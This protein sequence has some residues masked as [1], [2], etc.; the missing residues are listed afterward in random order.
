MCDHDHVAELRR[1]LADLDGQRDR[2]NAAFRQGFTVGFAHGFDL[3]EKNRL[4]EEAELWAALAEKVRQMGRS[5]YLNFA[6]LEHAR[7]GGPRALAGLPRD[8]DYPGRNA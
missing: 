7:Y 6:E 2:E 3:G 1:L 4:R 5:R 8:G